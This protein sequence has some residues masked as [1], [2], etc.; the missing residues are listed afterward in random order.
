MK[1]FINKINLFNC[2]TLPRK[3]FTFY[4]IALLLGS[5][6]L[7]L[8]I[9]RNQGTTPLSF[10]DAIFTASSAFST[11]GLSL[12]NTGTYFSLFGQTI[13][14]ILLQ[15]GGLGLMTI[16]V[17]LFLFLGKKIGI[18]ER[19]SATNERGNGAVGGSVDLLK[20]AII[21][22][23]SIELIAALLF[24]LRYYFTYLN[25][26]YFD[27]NIFKILYAGL[28]SAASS[29]NN[30]GVDIFGGAT[31]ISMF[32][33]DYF[34]QIL[35]MICFILG[36]LGFPVL[37][38]IRNFFVCK[39][40]KKKFKLSYFS[41]FVLRIYFS[42]A[43]IAIISVFAVE[44]SS[45]TIL[46]DTSKPLMQRIF[47]VIF[48]TF[49]TRNTGFATID[50]NEFATGTQII[51]SILMWI[52]AAPA[53]TGGGVRVTTFFICI[54]AL[55]SYSKNKKEVSFLDRK[56]PDN[57]VTKSLLVVFV[58]QI[59][60]L[61][62]AIIL[63]TSSSEI[64]FMQAFFESCSAFGTSGLSLGITSSLN[65]VSKITILL[66][67]F[68]GQIGVSSTILMWSNKKTYNSTQT[69]P[70]QDILIN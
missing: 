69:L 66:L 70:E 65:A 53:S 68:I 46:Y 54:L 60:V 23:F 9:S 47:Y 42:I 8:P 26:P 55:L 40:E 4:F 50:M 20:S 48:N 44:L 25:N 35:T 38:D 61:V 32:A 11:T 64:T 16:K 43:L 18:K 5:C 21:T 27:G 37:C 13:I 10:L 14:L 22:I 56:I 59:L 49:S 12:Y 24:S 2:K 67:M 3:I 15:I 36:G 41:K 39:K 30:A 51:F 1:E 52:G 57:T 58:S 6:L 62:A 31:S 45:G 17:L 29:V 33:N 19:I 7:L 63:V 34:I 28:F